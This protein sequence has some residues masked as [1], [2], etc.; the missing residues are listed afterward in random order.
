M[1]EEAR[2]GAENNKGEGIKIYGKIQESILEE[3][4]NDDAEDL[5]GGRKDTFDTYVRYF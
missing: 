1:K 3:D 4:A 5:Y 2:E